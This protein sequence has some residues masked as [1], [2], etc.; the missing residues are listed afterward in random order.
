MAGGSGLVGQA[1]QRYLARQAEITVLSRSGAG[2]KW[3][4][5]SVGAWAT[6][7]EG[8][9]VVIN[10]AGRSVNCRYTT[11]NFTDMTH[12]RVASTRA[13]GQAIASLK[14]PPALWLQMSTATIYAHR[15]DAPNDEDTGVIGGSEPGLPSKW[16]ASVGIAKAWE[17]ELDA[18]KTPNTRKVA[19]RSAIVMSPDKGGAFDHFARAAKW[20][21]LG[22]IGKGDQ[23]VSWV[24]EED[25]ANAVWFLMEHTEIS[26]P[27]NIAA[28]SPIPNAEF[29]A[30]IRNAL[31]TRLGIP[32]SEALLVLGMKAMKSE[33]ELVLKSRRVVPGRLTKAGFEFKYETWAAACA[34]L[35]KRWKAQHTGLS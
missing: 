8:A 14:N 2:V 16:R 34:E 20:G 11:E 6:E 27:V 32:V 35:M 13:I 4:G 9:D 15:F 7:L 33:P 21:V 18:A 5:V 12:S 30:A 1:L 31:G 19:L 10:L 22:K 25:F 29:N 17:A 24:H 28:P 3:D 23:Y 26:G